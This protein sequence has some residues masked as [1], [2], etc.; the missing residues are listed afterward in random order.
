MGLEFRAWGPSRRWRGGGA[1][2]PFAPVR[3]PEAATR[4]LV[5][6][7]PAPPW[8]GSSSKHF[9]DIFGRLFY[10]TS[11]KLL[12]PDDARATAAWIAHWA[13]EPERDPEEA[14]TAR[15]AAARLEQV[16]GHDWY[17]EWDL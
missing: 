10:G 3:V 17:L 1:P 9:D 8:R 5:A 16:A 11:D 15:A 13:E 6:A 2:R 7:D 14:S 12:T 4:A